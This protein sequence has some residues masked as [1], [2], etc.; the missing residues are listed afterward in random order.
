MVK[1]FKNQQKIKNEQINFLLSDL[2]KSLEQYKEFLENKDK[3]L[4]EAKES[5]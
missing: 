3:H 4:A 5:Y 2:E 1:T